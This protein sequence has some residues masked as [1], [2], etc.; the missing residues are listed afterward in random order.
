MAPLLQVHDGAINGMC[1]NTEQT[2]LVTCGDDGT[3][4]VLDLSSGQTAFRMEGHLDAVNDVAF[5]SDGFGI[6]SVSFQDPSGTSLGSFREGFGTF[7]G[8]F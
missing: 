5:T 3:I 1:Y 8:P 4:H 6:V 2:Q 7:S